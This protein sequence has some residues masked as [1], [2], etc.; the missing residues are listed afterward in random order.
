VPPGDLERAVFVARALDRAVITMFNRSVL[1]KDVGPMDNGAASL[2]WKKEPSGTSADPGRTGT[3]DSREVLPAG[4]SRCNAKAGSSC[5]R[6][7]AQV[8]SH[9]HDATSTGN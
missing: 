2:P 4:T 1:Q 7:R 6:A 3:G 5:A 8:F 9:G